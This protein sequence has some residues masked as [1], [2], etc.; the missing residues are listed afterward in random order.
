MDFYVNAFSPYYTI[1]MYEKLRL[2]SALQQRYKSYRYECQAGQEKAASNKP[3]HDSD[4]GGGKDEE[5]NF[6]N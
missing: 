1:V 6:D 2:L 4:Y 3:D 5:Q